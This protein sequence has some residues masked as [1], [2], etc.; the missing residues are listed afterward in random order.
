MYLLLVHRYIQL[1]NGWAGYDG[2]RFPVM[3]VTESVL[4][5]SLVVSFF[6]LKKDLLF[7]SVENAQETKDGGS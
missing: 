6:Y 7:Q 5:Q 3:V 1:P 2:K 4:A